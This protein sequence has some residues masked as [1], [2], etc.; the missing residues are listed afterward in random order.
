VK[1][2]IDANKLAKALLLPLFLSIGINLSAMTLQ[3]PSDTTRKSNALIHESS[4]YLRQHAYNPVNWVSWSSEAFAKA[5]AEDKLVLISIGYSSC[6]W[7]HVMERES[8]E[9]DSVAKL[10][11]DHFVCIKVD[12]EE[13]PDV[14]DIY[15][16]AVQLMTGQGG[17]PLNCFALPDGRPVFGGTYF[18]KGNWMNILKQLHESYQG[19]KRKFQEYAEQLTNGVASSEVI[20]V[21]TELE[22]FDATRLDEMVVNWKRGFDPLQGGPNRAPKFPMPNNYEFLMAYAHLKG[23]T[24]VMNHVDLSLRKMAMGGIY[25]QIG[26]GFS[27]YSVDTLWKVPHFEKMLYDNAQLVSLY[28]KAFQRTQDPLYR[29]VVFE[30]VGWLKREMMSPVGSFYS[31]LDADSEGEEGKFYVWNEAELKKVLGRKYDFAKSYYGIGPL[32]EWEGNHILMQAADDVEFAKLNDISASQLEELKSSVTE[33]LM[34]VR[35]KRIRPGLD[36]KSL[37]AWNAMM[38]V[39]LCDAYDAFGDEAFLSSAIGTANWIIQKQIGTDGILKHTFKDGEIKID[40]FLDDYAFTIEAFVRLYE[41]TFDE[42]WLAKARILT[43][44]VIAHFME[45]SGGMFYYTSI[46]GEQLIARKMEIADN[47][48]PSSNSCL[49]KSLYKLG[50]LLQNKTY[51]S[52]SEQMLANVYDGMEKYGSAYSNWGLL[53]LMMTDTYYEI[54]VTGSDFKSKRNEL[55]KA[56]L[57]NAIFMGGLE[58]QL[59]LLQGKFIDETTI[60]VCIEN[61]CKKPTREVA[62]ALRQMKQISAQ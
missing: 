53:G 39:G 12:R 24:A 32:T 61:M 27:R 30:T 1:T 31:A 57:P 4:P 5:V 20:D 14:D 44:D 46:S 60:F 7:C 29:E 21:P 41:V 34:A 40:G 42:I 2:Q 6:H 26:G 35:D 50:I 9:D 48:I 37:T 28:S 25:D 13:R 19:D 38:I 52:M 16:T 59:P 55:A 11:N 18:P 62:E 36:D 8:F 49:A 23:D 56:Y 54:A 43:D 45:P 58:S 33:K 47:V 51:I 17:W 3:H 22:E 15:M 10:M